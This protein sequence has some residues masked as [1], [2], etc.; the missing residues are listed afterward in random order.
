MVFERPDGESEQLMEAWREFLG[1]QCFNAWGTCTFRVPARS[2]KAALRR[3]G[4]LI[5]R[6]CRRH[7]V[8]PW[9]FMVAEPFKLGCYHVHFMLWSWRD[10]EKSQEFLRGLEQHLET[11]AGYARVRVI[12]DR[13][14]QL[15]GYVGKY[16]TKLNPEFCFVGKKPMD[17]KGVDDRGEWSSSSS[18]G[19]NF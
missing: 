7:D 12:D 9:F 8:A 11:A 5:R 14:G 6:Y 10:K 3:A 4:S 13:V 2:G 19:K 1:A 17:L 18:D 16:L 15:R